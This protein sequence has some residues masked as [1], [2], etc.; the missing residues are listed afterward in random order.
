MAVGQEFLVKKK[1]LDSGI[2]QTEEVTLFHHT[3]SWH[4]SSRSAQH[5]VV[6]YFV[7]YFVKRKRVDVGAL[8]F[9]SIIV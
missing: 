3:A 4:I 2:K 5:L 8:S 1:N 6:V 7:R 9:S